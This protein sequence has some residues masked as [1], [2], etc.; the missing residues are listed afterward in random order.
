[1]NDEL[2]QLVRERFQRTI[3][4]ILEDCSQSELSSRFGVAQ[5]NISS[6]S[7]GRQT[8][9]LDVIIKVSEFVGQPAWVYLAYLLGEDLL[10]SPGTSIEGQ[11]RVLSLAR[12]LEIAKWLMLEIE[13]TI[14]RD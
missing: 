9:S 4:G 12:K 8:P 11:I 1:M 3:V 13:E 10:K 14:L 7:R 2:E 6:Y 5:S